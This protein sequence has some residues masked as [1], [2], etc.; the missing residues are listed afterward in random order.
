MIRVLTTHSKTTF[1]TDKGPQLG[2]VPDAFRWFEDDLNKRL[3]NKNIR[4]HVMFIPVAHDDLIPALLDGRG[5]IVASTKLITAWRKE[6]V[7]FTNPT[8]NG[9]SSIIVTGPGVPPIASVQD[10]GGKELYLRASDV[11][12]QGVERFNALLAASGKPPVKIRPAPEVLADE[13]I[14]EM[15]NAGLVPMTMVDDYIAQFWQQIFPGIV[16]NTSAAVRTDGQTAM[17]V[18]KNC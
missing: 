6:Q 10:L 1:F 18:R 13:D 7:D 9:I 5:D 16:L 4:V 14:L 3:N 15:V 2:M 11:S 17:M 8:R 12:S